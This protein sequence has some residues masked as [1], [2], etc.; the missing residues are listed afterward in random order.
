MEIE[1]P[2]CAARYEVAASLLT[3]GRVVRCTRCARTWSPS[4]EGEVPAAPQR[5]PSDVAELPSDVAAADP[6][7]R[8]V[9]E[10]AIARKSPPPVA[11]GWAA[12]LLVLAA[13]VSV[14]IHYRAAIA[15]AWPP[16]TRLYAALGLPLRH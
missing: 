11:I 12:S 10:T 1:C 3:P 5:S 15:T 9:T 7:T 4:I 6:P 8:P 2:A 16:A 14:A 13:L